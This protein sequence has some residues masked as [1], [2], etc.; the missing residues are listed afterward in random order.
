MSSGDLLSVAAGVVIVILVASAVQW[1]GD[2]RPPI[3]GIDDGQHPPLTHPPDPTPSPTPVSLPAPSKLGYVEKPVLKYKTYL[4]P[5]NISLFGASDPSWKTKEC[6]VFASLEE[7]HGGVTGTFT[8][9]YPIWRMNCTVIPDNNPGS[10][11]FRAILVDASTNTIIEGMEL[12]GPGHVV[13][14]IEV[15][16]G[17]YYL[18]VECRHAHFTMNMETKKEFLAL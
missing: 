8:V 10:T 5:D 18:I 13:K 11:L 7:E 1:W 6:V 14:N 12:C 9:P 3:D 17:E 4:L 2:D 15:S 16:N